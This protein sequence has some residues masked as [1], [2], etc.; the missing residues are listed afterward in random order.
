MKNTVELRQNMPLYPFPKNIC[1]SMEDQN[2]DLH[3]E[4][5]KH[6]FCQTRFSTLIFACL[7]V[8][9]KFQEQEESSIK[10]LIADQ[11]Y[12]RLSTPVLKIFHVRNF[13]LIITLPNESELCISV[14]LASIFSRLPKTH[15]Y[16]NTKSM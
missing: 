1:A 15:T 5:H 8:C 16:P 13:K 9:T 11:G 12:V 4:K 6:N 3:R 14:I 2:G 10:N 7:E